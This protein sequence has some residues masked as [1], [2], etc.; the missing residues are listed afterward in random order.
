[1]SAM[2]VEFFIAIRY[3]KAR[4]KAFF[5]LLTTFIA[6]GGITLGVASLV[7][8][9]AVMS[10]FQSD[11]RNKILGIQPHILVTRSDGEPFEDYI[12]VE[13]KIKTNKNVV[14]VLPFIYKQGIVRGIN[15]SS[16]AGI[17]IKAVDYSKEDKIL[18]LSKQIVISDI[19]FNGENIGKRSIILGCEL[20]KNISTD[21]GDEVI[22]MFPTSLGSIPTMYKFNVSAVI[23]SGMYDF[24][25]SLGFIDLKEGQSLF[26]MPNSITGLDIHTTNFEKASA[27]AAEL[28]KNLSYP[29]KTK[30]WF[31][32]NKNLF[33]ALKLEK[34]MMFLILG[35]IIIV[36][37][38][39]VISNL[40][41]LSVQKSKEIGIMSAMG[42][43]NYS[44]SK[45]F[46]YEG[47]I[48]GSLG[49]VF[50]IIFGVSVSFALKY[51]DIFKLPKGVYYVDKLP[52]SIIPLDI[53]TVAL[54]AFI[55]SILAGLYPA[56]QVAKL[57][58]LETI[59]YG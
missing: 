2:S 42:F 38:F 48:V 17:I 33:S 22:L 6:V 24:D 29:Y 41:L 9:L 8:T 10:G 14:S 25:S 26:S 46:F 52:V 56:R 55:I 34:I 28:Q 1:M 36:A 4:R 47:L 5:S 32:M 13:D 30:A 45:I 54:S 16:T 27:T 57:D 39:N 3:L 49:I 51:L 44:I 23:E 15:S 53:L 40:L 20:V 50:G 7:I 11:I 58:P 19:K 31:D 35:L 43:S 21:A 12:S 59:R 37:A 18:N